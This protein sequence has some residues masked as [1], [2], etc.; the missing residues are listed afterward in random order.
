MSLPFFVA[1]S[2]RLGWGRRPQER[3]RKE[4]MTIPEVQRVRDQRI[5]AI[6]PL[7]SPALLHHEL[8]L[9]ADLHDTVLDSRRQVEDIVTGCDRRLVVVTAPCSVHAPVAAAEYA[10]RLE[11]QAGRFADDLLIVMRVY[12]EKPRST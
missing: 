1:T 9:V 11:E 6:V 10:D 2:S 12:F 8:P 4:A 5:D 7:M 3:R